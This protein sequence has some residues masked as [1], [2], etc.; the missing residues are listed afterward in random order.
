MPLASGQSR[1]IKAQVNNGETGLSN[2]K[3]SYGCQR[4]DG[5]WTNQGQKRCVLLNE[6]D[7]PLDDPGRE[8][9]QN[10]NSTRQVRGL[11]WD[12]TSS[13]ASFLELRVGFN[14][15]SPDA[16]GIGP[17]SGHEGRREQRR[18]RLV[19][20]EV[21][22]VWQGMKQVDKRGQTAAVHYIHLL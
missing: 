3:W 22:L 5:R 7:I 11:L 4:V 6:F 20:E 2:R 15:T 18:H 13:L 19:K 21:I 16:P 9:R 14:L 8:T 12:F 17:V 10:F 1:A